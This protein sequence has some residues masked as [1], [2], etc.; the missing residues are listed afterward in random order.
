[1]QKYIDEFTFRFNTRDFTDNQ[2]FDLYLH[3]I[4]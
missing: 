3:H 2:R 1:M 4:A